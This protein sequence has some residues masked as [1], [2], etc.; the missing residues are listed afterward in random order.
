LQQNIQT[1][2]SDEARSMNV[3]VDLDAYEATAIRPDTWGGN[4]EIERMDP[5]TGRVVVYD[6]KTKKP[7][8][9]K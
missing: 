1:P 7:L 9:Y 4:E 3:P 5:K 8:R 6:A 2:A